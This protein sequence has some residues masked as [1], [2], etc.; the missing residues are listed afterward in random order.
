MVNP[1]DYR[2]Y[3]RWTPV[4]GTLGQPTRDGRDYRLLGSYRQP[5]TLGNTRDP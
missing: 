4:P 5:E 1:L 2:L 3:E